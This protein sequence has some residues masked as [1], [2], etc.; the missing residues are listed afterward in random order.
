MRMSKAAA[1]VKLAAFALA[2]CIACVATPATAEGASEA[3][4][5]AVSK[6]WL[7]LVDGGGYGESWDGAAAFL[8]GAVSRAQFVRALEGARRPL[9]AL[10]SRRLIAK[11]PA[12]TL[13]G[14]PDG[15][16]VV[17]QFRTVFA[18]KRSA[19]ETITPMLE[20]DGAWRTAGYFIR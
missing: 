14:A 4:A 9:G 10:I 19:V 1:K 6:A 7:A 3:A 13:P 16:Y 18:N 12:T 17:I 2:A 15:N 8:K 20:A 5:V 11:R